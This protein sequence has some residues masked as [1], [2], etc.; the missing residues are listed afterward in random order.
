VR[1]RSWST[2]EVNRVMIGSIQPDGELGS[3]FSVDSSTII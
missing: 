3:C 2:I 1:E